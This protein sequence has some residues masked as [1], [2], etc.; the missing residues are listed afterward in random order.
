M[1]WHLFDQYWT[2]LNCSLNSESIQIVFSYCLNSV[3][4]EYG[5][6]IINI[7]NIVKISIIADN[8]FNIV[9]IVVGPEGSP[10]LLLLFFSFSSSFF[11]S[12]SSSH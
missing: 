6:N 5:V 3:N 10:T 2:V 8:I 7:V 12:F 1:H 4:H 11:S 9:N